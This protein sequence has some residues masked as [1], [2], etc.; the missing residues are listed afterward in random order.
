VTSGQA[1]CPFQR[2]MSTTTAGS[3]PIRDGSVIEVTR[4]K[5][6]IG[7]FIAIALVAVAAI[8]VGVGVGLSSRSGNST[9][10]TA[11]NDSASS[12]NNTTTGSSGS[13]GSGSGTGSGVNLGNNCIA[14]GNLSASSIMTQDRISSEFRL[15]SNLH[16]DGVS[17]RMRIFLP[18]ANDSVFNDSGPVYPVVFG[19]HGSGGLTLAP[20]TVGQNCATTMDSRYQDITQ[21]VTT[22]FNMSIIWIDSYT[23][24]DPRFCKDDNSSFDP[25]RVPGMDS[26]LQQETLR[27][28]D[29]TFAES[30][31]CKWKRIDCTRMFRIGTSEGAQGILLPTHRY[32]DASLAQLFN[33]SS[34]KNR[35]TY[36]ANITYHTLPK[37]R[38][39]PVFIFPISPGCGFYSFIPFS[40]TGTAQDMFYPTCPVYMHIGQ[41]DTVPASCAVAVGT[42]TREIQALA[43]KAAESI[44]TADYRYNYVI[45]PNTTHD[46]YNLQKT[47]VKQALRQLVSQYP[48]K[49]P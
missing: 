19:Y 3:Q 45:Y 48:V 47:A 42:G 7:I 41:N 5:K 22:E 13:S 9:A 40:T 30:V 16:P 27:V 44:S 12:N 1:V 24:R 4:R 46:V 21:M 17:L 29:L 33:S 10:S 32:L 20:S 37:N 14:S 18:K 35:L 23:S 39:E 11:N 8:A 34:T 31:L 26:N 2:I 15:N 25:Y 49:C 43:I 6:H 28:Y 38:T 36:L